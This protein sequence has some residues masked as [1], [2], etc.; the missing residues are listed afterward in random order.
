MLPKPP[1]YLGDV[2][3]DRTLES[4][5][6]FSRI[7]SSVELTTEFARD[8]RFNR[9]KDLFTFRFD[10][11][12][13]QDVDGLAHY[14]EGVH[15][16]G[17]TMGH[18]FTSSV[19]SRLLVKTGIAEPDPNDLK[20]LNE[21]GGF[22]ITLSL[23]SDV[24]ASSETML[25]TLRQVTPRKEANLKHAQFIASLC[26]LF[27]LLHELAHA[28]LGHCRYASSTDKLSIFREKSGSTYSA[29]QKVLHALEFDADWFAAAGLTVNLLQNEAPFDGISMYSNDK[30]LT[31]ECILAALTINTLQWNS[32]AIVTGARS[33][34]HP[35]PLT[36]CTY[37]LHCARWSACEH[38]CLTDQ[39]SK[40]VLNGFLR[41][42]LRADE[43]IGDIDQIR[44]V[45]ENRQEYAAEAGQLAETL[46]ELRSGGLED[47]HYT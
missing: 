43:Y 24:F 41:K 36:R 1:A 2:I 14:C 5:Q 9:L 16:L 39:A 46:G 11:F 12:E 13:N 42:I 19:F 3:P 38:G 47:Y 27:A 15:F 17:L 23:S 28:V 10:I 37:L 22:P 26:D 40:D 34:S 6:A 18:V 44:N 45:D 8:N 25:E 35:H 21:I 33:P 29:D 7:K 31:L 32:H 20:D 30:A 4:L